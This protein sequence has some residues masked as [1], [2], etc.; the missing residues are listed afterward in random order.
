MLRDRLLFVK[1]GRAIFISHLDLMHTF[2]RAFI[3][4]GQSIRYTEGF[5]PHSY[6]TIAIPLPLGVESECEM[7]DFE[8]VDGC[9]LDELPERLNGKLPEGITVL[10]AWKSERKFSNIKWL[11]LTGEL[12][13]SGAADC[14]SKVRELFSSESVVVSKKTKRGVS[15]IDILPFVKDLS[16]ENIPE[17]VR[18]TAVVSAQEPTISPTDITAACETAVGAAAQNVLFRRLC[19]Y[20]GDMNEFE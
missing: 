10:K 19:V 20:D 18:I 4:A 3:R 16:P 11:K 1:E 6:L 12:T 2:Q 17:G 9:S 14:A 5:N 15:D 7:L 8:L 13:F